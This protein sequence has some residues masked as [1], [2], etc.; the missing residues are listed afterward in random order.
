MPTY[1]RQA[2]VVRFRVAFAFIRTL[3][4][5]MAIRN[6]VAIFA[7]Y[8]LIA[9]AGIKMTLSTRVCGPAGRFDTGHHE[10]IVLIVS[11]RG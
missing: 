2:R 8:V 4:V 10:T 6:A 11:H 1:R 9:R 5:S 7:A 3:L